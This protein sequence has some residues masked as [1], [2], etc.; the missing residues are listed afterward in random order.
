MNRI[1]TSSSALLL[2]VLT[3]TSVNAGSLALELG[4]SLAVKTSM[5]LPQVD[6]LA[7]PAIA[8]PDLSVKAS[9][10]ELADGS[11][12]VMVEVMNLSSADYIS[13]PGQQVLVVEGQNGARSGQVPFV[14]LNRGDVILWS[15]T[16]QPF[17]FPARYSAYLSFDPDLLID[18]NL[19][20]DD[21]RSTNN[22]VALTTLR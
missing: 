6:A 17:E 8:C 2:S 9:Q 21:C 11:I 1:A 19:R 14:N 20:N 16:F 7:T 5:R 12:R 3:A 13:A 10:R 22:R 18:G 15:D 4:A